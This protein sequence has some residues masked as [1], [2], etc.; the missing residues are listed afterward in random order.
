LSLHL[1]PVD[2]RAL[3]DVVLAL[4]KPLIGSQPLELRNRIPADAP[5]VMA[6]ENRLQQILFNLLGNAVK[7]TQ[8]GHVEVSARREN[9]FLAVTVSD[10]G[11]GIP[12]EK[13][14]RIFESFEQADGSIER[15]Y[16]GAG[17]GLAVTKQLVDLHGGRI[18]V[19]SK[20]GEGTAM[21]FTLPVSERSPRPVESST[22]SFRA[23]WRSASEETLQLQIEAP[24]EQVDEHAFHILI[25]DDE[26]INRQV[27][28][29]HLTR[30]R[31]RV[32]QASSGPEALRLLE[33]EGPFDLA[34][35][36]V[37][38]P[39]MSGY[40]ACRKIRT[41]HPA[42]ELPII[43][44]TALNQD[45]DMVSAFEAG[46]NDFL[47][48]PVSRVELLARVKT[49]LQLLDVNRNL[50]RKVAERTESLNA[51]NQELETLDDI[52]KTVNQEI[53][54]EGVLETLLRQGLLLF[55]QAEKG[56]YL[57]RDPADGRF[58]FV[59]AVGYD[60][61]SL[62][63]VSFSL[64]ELNKRYGLPDFEIEE[65]VYL[66]REAE[67][68]SEASRALKK[69]S[70]P[71]GMLA[72]SIVLKDRLEGVLVWDNLADPAAFAHPDVRKMARFRRHALTAV[73]KAL[74][75]RELRDKNREILA[76][77]KQLVMQEKMAS[78]G[79]LT[80]GIAHEIKNPLNF[81][82][83][84]SG[85][86]MEL[87]REIK[88]ALDAQ[89]AAFDDAAYAEVA[90]ML[91]DLEE[92]SSLVNQH[93]QRANRIVES[94]MNFARGEVD[95][96]KDTEV[97]TLVNEFANIAA[98]GA[99][100]KDRAQRVSM[101]KDLD[102]AVGVMRLESQGISRVVINLV[103]NAIDAV[104]A[105]RR[106]APADYQPK[107]WV[108]T[109]DLG[110]RIQIRVEDNGV[111]V[112][113]ENVEKI[114]TPFYTTKPSSSGNIGL[115]LPITYD[116]VVQEHGGDLRVE[117]VEGRTA[118]VVELPKRAGK[119]RRRKAARAST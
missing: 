83:N 94:M 106:S 32:S 18:W 82:N 47:T 30:A 59:A 93:G 104:A 108:R 49:H 38:M 97:N 53:E 58:R 96:W 117:T 43:I 71:R 1:R 23:P 113:P 101:D 24:A 21:T 2:L 35:L 92:N 57:M 112:S 70:L 86:S 61:T 119:K 13:F 111:G 77:Q 39:Q 118:F 69:I 105:K 62:D 42:H 78:M 95:E 107:V 55:P 66:I 19:E 12:A 80:A 88:Q 11:I 72:M 40:E 51:R 27:L 26:P 5:P 79:V 68:S 110:D 103:N 37:M 102:P 16:G 3:T 91:K 9:G 22:L 34:L 85:L 64:E 73:A 114:F 116:I 36:D 100:P 54:L 15:T 7:F 81:V 63:R 31:Y 44:L 46:A 8:K 29:N 115:G 50:E 76:A 10:T 60:L 67:Q 28:I 99:Q 48:K 87:S 65:G 109:K 56:T 41:R 25:V 20:V 89:R 17:L 33:Q 45:A 84:F 75:L 14:G 52:V 6:D 98:H 74:A 90:E 4:S